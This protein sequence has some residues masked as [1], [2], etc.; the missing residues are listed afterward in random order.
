[1]WAGILLEVPIRVPL[2]VPIAAALR[3]A[4]P[5]LLVSGYE[6][7]VRPVPRRADEYPALVRGPD[8]SVIAW[9]SPRG[10]PPPRL[11]RFADCD[12]PPT[13]VGAEFQMV[14][15]ARVLGRVSR[16]S[17]VAPRHR[18]TISATTPAAM[19]LATMPTRICARTPS[20]PAA[21]R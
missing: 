5:A 12:S 11:E 18:T 3:R 2:K 16:P 8:Y 7:S 19:V 20:A 6:Q 9:V 4:R 10:E 15:D 17:Q 21:R 13:G 1:M 14:L